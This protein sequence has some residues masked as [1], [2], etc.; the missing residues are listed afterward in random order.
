MHK[1]D[2]IFS[3]NG[4]SW[5]GQY[6]ITTAARL[7][8]LFG[9]PTFDAP[10]CDGGQMEWT[11][12][13]DGMAITVYD[14]QS[15]SFDPYTPVRWHIGAHSSWNAMVAQHVLNNLINGPTTEVHPALPQQADARGLQN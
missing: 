1:H 4:T 3:A 12:D 2:D 14:R 8:E 15:Y 10:S 9:E 7:T 13:H 5:H 11:L 6:I